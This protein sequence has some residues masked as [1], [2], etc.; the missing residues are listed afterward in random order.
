MESVWNHHHSFT[1]A[2]PSDLPFCRSEITPQ[3]KLCDMCCHLANMIEA[4][5]KISFAYE[6]CHLLPNYFGPCYCYYCYVQIIVVSG[7]VLWSHSCGLYLIL[8]VCTVIDVG[9]LLCWSDWS[10]HHQPI[11]SCQSPAASWKRQIHRGESLLCSLWYWIRI[12]LNQLTS[13]IVMHW[14]Y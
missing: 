10:C 14:P 13:L 4:T 2:D 12:H 5:S 9:R 8:C 7:W 11:R 3:D 6:Q 1:I